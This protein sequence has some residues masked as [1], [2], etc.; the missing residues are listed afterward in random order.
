[1]RVV[2]STSD[3]FT[4]AVRAALPTMKFHAAEIGGKPVNQLVQQPFGFQLSR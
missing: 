3:E 4:A 2:S 1:V